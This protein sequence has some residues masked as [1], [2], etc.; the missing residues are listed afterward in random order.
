[1]LVEVRFASTGVTVAVALISASLNSTRTHDESCV[2]ASDKPHRERAEYRH[3]HENAEAAYEATL[4]HD[5]GNEERERNVEVHEY[6]LHSDPLRFRLHK[7][8]E[9]EI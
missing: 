6:A 1:M 9:H 8:R 2:P 7:P 4:D 5:G 3:G